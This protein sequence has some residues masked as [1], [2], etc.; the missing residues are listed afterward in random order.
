[1]FSSSM[2]DRFD[3]HIRRIQLGLRLLAHGARAHTACEWSEISPDRLATLKR[4]WLPNVGAGFRGPAPTS[5]HVFWRSGL[6]LREAAVF[7]S[8][9]HSLYRLRHGTETI[10]SLKPCLENGEMLC[11]A[12]EIFREWEPTSDITL[13]QAALLAQGVARSIDISLCRCRICQCAM[14]LDRGA[15]RRDT[16]HHC[17]SSNRRAMLE[18]HHHRGNQ[19]A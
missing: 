7:S 14:I 11:E 13:D 18:L 4:Q 3:R 10:Q 17:R 1:M 15:T 5:F 9:H 8:I 16:C 6:R 19:M 12:F 2:S